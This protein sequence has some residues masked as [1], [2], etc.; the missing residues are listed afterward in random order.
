MICLCF[1][2][3]GVVLHGMQRLNKLASGFQDKTKEV[4]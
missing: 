3:G 2:A 1:G 4:E